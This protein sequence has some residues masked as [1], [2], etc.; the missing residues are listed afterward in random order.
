MTALQAGERP[1]ITLIDEQAD[2]LTELAISI[3]ERNPNVSRLLLQEI[4]RARIVEAQ[5]IPDEVVT[6]G[7]LVEFV[8]QKDGDRHEVRLVYPG[9]ADIAQGRLSILTPVGAGLIGLSAGQ[10]ISWPDRSG[11]ERLLTI[12][13]VSRPA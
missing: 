3:R 13:R 11:K 1:A 4:D 7:C 8:D 6:M 5:E 12:E 10:S 9:D 2:A